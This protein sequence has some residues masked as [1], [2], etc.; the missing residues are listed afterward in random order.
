[1]FLSLAASL[2]TACDKENNDFIGSD[3]YLNSFSLEKDGVVYMS[4]HKGN[5]EGF[6]GERY[7]SDYTEREMERIIKEGYNRIEALET[8]QSREQPCDEDTQ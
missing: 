8:E 6:A 1:M 2:F 5:F 7:F 4:F 3:N